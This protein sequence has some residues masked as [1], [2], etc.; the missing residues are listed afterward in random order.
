MKKHAFRKMT[1]DDFQARIK[2]VDP[3]YVQASRRPEATTPPAPSRPFVSLLLGFGWAFV[4]LSVARN[5]DS[6]ETSLLRGKLDTQYHDYIFYGLAALLAISA[7]MLAMHLLRYLFACTRGATK[8]NSGGLLFGAMLAAGFVYTPD[9]VF[10]AAFGLLDTNSRSLIVA[11]A[12]KMPV[13]LGNIAFV[14]SSGGY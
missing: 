11:A 10:E 14:S 8:G 2:R 3:C 5:R 12:D 13:D 4:C 6:I 9:S 1:Q 7:V